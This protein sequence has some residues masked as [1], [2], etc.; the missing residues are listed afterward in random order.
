MWERRQRRRGQVKVVLSAHDD[1]LYL[2][3]PNRGE[4]PVR[5]IGI[6][7]QTLTPILS[8][9]SALLISG[10]ESRVQVPDMNAPGLIPARDMATL[11]MGRDQLLEAGLDFAWPVVAGLTTATGDFFHAGPLKLPHWAADENSSPRN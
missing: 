9:E 8:V 3:V 1:I 6:V 5:I 7:L 2:E 10:H 4:H 11:T